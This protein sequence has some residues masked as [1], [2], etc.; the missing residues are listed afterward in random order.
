MVQWLSANR[1]IMATEL[2]VDGKHTRGIAVIRVDPLWAYQGVDFFEFD[3]ELVDLRVGLGETVYALYKENDSSPDATL[4]RLHLDAKTAVVDSIVLDS[5]WNTRGVAASPASAALIVCATKPG[6]PQRAFYRL[7]SNNGT[8]QDDSLYVCHETELASRAMDMTDTG[9]LYF[10]SHF[11][12]NSA[13]LVMQYKYATPNTFP[14][15]VAHVPG[16][17]DK[18][19]AHPT[20]PTRVLIHR[21]TYQ[22]D[23]T[24]I[25]EDIVEVTNTESYVRTRVDVRTSGLSCR[26]IRSDSPDWHPDGSA[27]AVPV[28]S[29]D[30]VREFPSAIW[31]KRF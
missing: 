19:A 15:V 5:S 29:S 2:M 11:V 31:I 28:W 16:V 25:R 13:S 4:G 8:L 14:L 17:V 18:V 21:H 23:Y 12:G 24:T 27:I 9:I 10:V 30:G 22:D 7:T 3:H 20:D 1:L 6:D 26:L